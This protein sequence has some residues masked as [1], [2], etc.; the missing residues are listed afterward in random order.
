MGYQRPIEGKCIDRVFNRLK[1]RSACD[2]ALTS[3]FDQFNFWWQGIKYECPISSLGAYNPSG[4]DIL[5]FFLVH[6]LLV[7][8][9]CKY[10]DDLLPLRAIND[11]NILL[12][13][14]KSEYR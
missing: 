4:S 11:N 5:K 3:E 12:I 10:E 6:Y 1:S 9:L 13:I 8:T 14:S 7:G 2:K